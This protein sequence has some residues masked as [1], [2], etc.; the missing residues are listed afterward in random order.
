MAI[1]AAVRILAGGG[2]M[3]SISVFASFSFLSARMVQN[4]TVT[5]PMVQ[6]TTCKDLN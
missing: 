1:T 5:N 2:L 4:D 3:Q 6:Q